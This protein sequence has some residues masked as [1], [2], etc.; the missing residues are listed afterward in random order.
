[1]VEMYD[2]FDTLID[3]VT[4]TIQPDTW[5]DNGGQGSI[6]GFPRGSLL[7]VSQTDDIH[8][9]L[10]QLLNMLRAAPDK[11]GVTLPQR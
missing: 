7:V 8:E 9:D 4:S 5:T 3:L 11:V 1:M 6:S 2:D 10:Q